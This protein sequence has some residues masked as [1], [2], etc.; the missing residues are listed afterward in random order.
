MPDKKDNADAGFFDWFKFKKEPAPTPSPSP[1]PQ[2]SE[3]SDL[4]M[5]DRMKRGQR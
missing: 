2:N 5:L 1:Q 3:D 4:D